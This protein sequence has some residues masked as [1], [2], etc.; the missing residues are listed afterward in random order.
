MVDGEL[1]AVEADGFAQSETNAGQVAT[2][3]N[4]REF[5]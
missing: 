2:V 1:Q 3:G 5:W 4:E